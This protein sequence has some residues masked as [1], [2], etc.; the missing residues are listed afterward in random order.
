MVGQVQFQF[1]TWIFKNDFFFNLSRKSQ[2][3]ESLSFD[4]LRYGGHITYDKVDIPRAHDDRLFRVHW[5]LDHDDP[6]LG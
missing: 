6:F 5:G 2:G 4:F 1:I 3:F